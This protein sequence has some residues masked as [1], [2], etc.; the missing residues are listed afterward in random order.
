MTNIGDLLGEQ[1]DRI[2]QDNIKIGDV[3]FINLDE[4]NGITPKNGDTF[5]DKFF[6]VLGFDGEGNVIGGVVINSNINYKLPASITDYQLP[7][8]VKQFPFLRYNSFINCSNLVVASRTKFS[9]STYRGEVSDKDV[10]ELIIGTIKESPTVNKKQ[11]KE[12][13]II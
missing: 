11:L 5:R 6:I 3:H 7:V 2:A 8:K 9:R 13:G 12:F 4:G 1:A 10:L